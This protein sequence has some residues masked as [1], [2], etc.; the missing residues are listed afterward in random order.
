MTT[1]FLGAPG[2]TNANYTC[3][4][5]QNTKED[6]FFAH[7]DKQDKL[8]H[9]IHIECAKNVARQLIDD[10]HCLLC[11]KS[12]HPLDILTHQELNEARDHKAAEKIVKNLDEDE[13]DR[14]VAFELNGEAVAADAGFG[15]FRVDVSGDAALA[16]AL[17]QKE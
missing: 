12:I 7:N 4:V 14:R 1:Q 13:G 5:C 10:N 11:K 6:D 2:A 16:K 15:L 9:H 17:H 3:L 8:I